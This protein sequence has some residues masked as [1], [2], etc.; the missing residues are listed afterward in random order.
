MA[1]VDRFV[2]SI[3]SARGHSPWS[4]ALRFHGIDLLDTARSPLFVD[5]LAAARSRGEENLGRSEPVTWNE[6]LRRYAVDRQLPRPIVEWR[7][8]RRS[9]RP[10]RDAILAWPREPTHVAVL[11]PVIERL[12]ETET[13]GYLVCH[14]RLFD[15]LVDT[16][17]TLTRAEWPDL[18]RRS[19]DATAPLLDRLEEPFGESLPDAGKIGLSQS[20]LE[21]ILRRSLGRQLPTIVE[22]VLATERLF[23]ERT[24]RALLV[25]N[26]L[27]I[28]G[29]ATARVADAA[30]VPTAALMH[31]TVTGDPL[32]RHHIVDRFLVYGERSRETLTTQGIESRRVTVTGNPRLGSRPEP[33]PETDTRV[34]R[35]GGIAPEQPWF[36]VASSGAGHRVSMAHHLRF[37][38]GIGAASSALPASRWVVK[39]HRKDRRTHYPQDPPYPVIENSSDGAPPDIYSWLRGPVAVVTSA[40]TV[41][42]EAMLMGV[43]VIT[44]DLADELSRVDFIEAGATIHCRTV[45]DLVRRARE[46]LER[47]CAPSGVSRRAQAFLQETFAHLDGDP[48]DASATAILDLARGGASND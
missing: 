5:L 44:V 22:T 46:T 42:I 26:D 16:Q 8:R 37:I 48:V 30:G 36:L 29:R 7:A 17:P 20:R 31:G 9:H 25:G 19:Q 12:A 2:D 45:A 38:E 33:A 24:P 34:T 27:T 15:A 3:S 41:A 14:P 35:I 39:L 13:T 10:P 18:V 32:Q 23:D 4:E 6:R 21:E 40:S 43:P 47:G 1:S 11:R 28:E